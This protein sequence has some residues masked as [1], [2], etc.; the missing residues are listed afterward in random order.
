MPGF[1]GCH[2][3]TKRK[4]HGQ[5]FTHPERAIE[6][7]LQPPCQASPEEH[8]F[9]W[10]SHARRLPP[11]TPTSPFT[12][13]CFRPIKAF[14]S[15]ERN[16]ET[17]KYGLTFNATQALVEGSSLALPCGRCNGCLSDKAKTW[18]LRCVHEAE[19]HERN[20]FITLTYDNETVPE[21]YSV[22][23]R[24]WQTFMKRL[25]RRVGTNS[26]RFFACGEYGD[27]G[28]RPHYHALL[29]NYDLPDKVFYRVNK[30]GDRIYRSD[31]LNEVWGNSELNEVGTVTYKSARY[32][33]GYIFKK[34]LGDKNPEHYLRTSPINGHVYQV[35][36]EFAVM[37][38]RP[39]L[40]TTWFEKF[41]TDAFPSDFLIVEGKRVKPPQ[42]YFDK[43]SEL[44]QQRIK[45]V[46][47]R[48]SIQPRQKLNSTSAR[49]KE[50]EEVQ[51]LRLQ[52]LQRPL[53]V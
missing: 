37:S 2:N 45:R 53:E 21:D 47:K 43:L 41:K 28:L 29:F 11:V 30:H 50:R 26:I 27:R 49:L 51:R 48:F 38:R 40:A 34:Q 8:S 13:T 36:K 1:P 14:R 25:R 42:F 5:A 33:A 20:C 52:R 3:P 39:G 9:A 19:M 10:S 23:L 16:P 7:E 18:A 17:G 46:R 31:F 6:E 35:A 32:C 4:S 44:E 12:V 15:R 22:K 24:D